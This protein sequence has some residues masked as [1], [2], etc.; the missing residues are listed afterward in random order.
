MTQRYEVLHSPGDVT[1]AEQAQPGALLGHD[2]MG[3]PY[4]VL[5]AGLE[6]FCPHGTDHPR[7]QVRTSVHVQYATPET[8]REEMRKIAALLSGGGAA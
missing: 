2:E 3:R 8:L 4:E 7:C 6:Y 5:D 1:G